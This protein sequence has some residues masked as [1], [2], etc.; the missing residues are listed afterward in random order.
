MGAGA[1]RLPPKQRWDGQCR[2]R[3][4]MS[5]SRVELL[6]IIVVRVVPILVLAEEFG[7]RARFTLLRP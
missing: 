7:Q 4:M 3:S 2:P 5:L 6:R 1:A